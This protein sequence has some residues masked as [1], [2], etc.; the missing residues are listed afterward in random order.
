MPPV[1]DALTNLSVQSEIRKEV[2]RDLI[3][4]LR[5]SPIEFLPN[6]VKFLLSTCDSDSYEEVSDFLQLIH[7]LKRTISEITLFQVLNGLRME[8]LADDSVSLKNTMTEGLVDV[9]GVKVLIYNNIRNCL[10]ANKQLADCWLKNI[11]QLGR[12]V[13]SR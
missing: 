4:T 2:R 7:I 6:I 12:E 11:S 13:K 5:S 1:L 9:D 3:D 10:L 8:L